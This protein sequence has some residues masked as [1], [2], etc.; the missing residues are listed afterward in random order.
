VFLLSEMSWPTTLTVTVPSGESGGDYYIWV[1]ATS[2]TNISATASL[3]ITVH[4]PYFNDVGIQSIDT[5]TD[6]GTYVMGNYSIRSTARNF[7]RNSQPEFNVSL[8]I[9]KLG[10]PITQTVFSD[11]ME[12]GT[13]GWQVIDLDGTTSQS[14]WK[15]VTSSSNSPTTSWWCGD[16]TKY[17]NKTAQLLISPSFSLKWALDANLS[18]YHKY[19]TESNYDYSSVDISNG[20]KWITLVTYDGN[21]PATFEP[22][23]ISL[24]DFIGSDDLRIRF[25]FTS[26]RFVVDDGWYIDDVNVT[27][28]FP[29]ETTI[30]G[31]VINHTT[32]IMVQ[33][34]TLQTGWDY[35]F[36]QIGDY[37]IYATTLLETDEW[38]KN[39]QSVIKIKILPSPGSYTILKEGWNLISIPLI[40]SNTSL[41]SVLESIQG[42]YDAVQWYDTTDTSKPWKHYKMG[43]P[44]GNDLFEINETMGFWIHI[45]QPGDTIFWYN[46][47]QPVVNRT[48]IFHEG[49]NLVG[50]PS[51]TNYNRTD[52]LNNL[53]FGSEVDSIWTFDASTQKWEEMGPSDYFEPGRGYWVHAKVKCTW[54]V[55]L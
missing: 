16:T 31:P 53:T 51:L 52:G 35:T 24:K 20:T 37:K 39:N 19:K 36:T 26:D 21:G 25:R 55:P 40:Q 33:D 46:G 18:F 3:I 45:T 7:G 47:T 22:V 8:E 41:S 48:I 43:K 30:Y 15:Q 54:E 28:E 38:D 17:T 23:V 5:F 42:K 29:T 10:P 4:V 49:W 44:Y 11:D 6:G 14:S 2:Q 13:N 27:A 34:G 1:N 32:G 9:R 12:S 50:Y